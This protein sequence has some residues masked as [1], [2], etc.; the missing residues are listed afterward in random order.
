MK[1]TNVADQIYRE[2]GNPTDTS[3]PVISYWLQSNVGLLNSA[4][5]TAYTV[6]ATTFEVEQVNPNDSSAYEE[7]GEDEAAIFKLIYKIHYQDIQIRRNNL[8]FSTQKAI[9]ITSDGHTVQLMSP[10]EIGKSLYS[11]RKELGE[12]LHKWVNWYRIA[13]SVP[14]QTVG[15][16]YYNSGEYVYSR[17]YL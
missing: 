15:D 14:R 16:D 5:N 13:K 6:N 3:I 7:M 2:L 10:G 4:I 11:Y 12:E 8:N 1:V 17:S 9:R